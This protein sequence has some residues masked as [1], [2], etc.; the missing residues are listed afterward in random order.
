[1]KDE[2]E[3]QVT[4]NDMINK[5]GLN[6]RNSFLDSVIYFADSIGLKYT[7]IQYKWGRKLFKG[8]YYL[9]QCNGLQLTKNPFW[10]EHKITS[11]QS[12]TLGIERY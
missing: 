4:A 11:C 2:N 10:S 9:I 3:K 12:Q 6:K 1:M 5:L 8:D 7:L